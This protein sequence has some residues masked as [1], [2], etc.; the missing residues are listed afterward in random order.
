MIA[1]LWTVNEVRWL[2]LNVCILII[3]RNHV[4]YLPEKWGGIVCRVCLPGSCDS[5]G[6]FCVLSVGRPLFFCAHPFGLYIKLSSA[7]LDD[8]NQ[9]DPLVPA[10]EWN[11]HAWMQTRKEK[12]F[13]QMVRDLTD[14]FQSRCLFFPLSGSL[15]RY[16][17][18]HE[19]AEWGTVPEV[20]AAGITVV[21][22]QILASN[23]KIYA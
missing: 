12:C 21:W 10:F 18:L 4:I 16:A 14:N 11:K 22:C 1:H 17:R 20:F 23:L 6:A 2:K 19:T 5:E 3:Q 7:V 15:G 8:Q 13:H 9:A